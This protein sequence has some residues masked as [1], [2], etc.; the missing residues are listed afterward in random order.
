M[1]RRRRRG[2][3]GDGDTL[4]GTL[5]RSFQRQA[6]EG[7]EQ[8]TLARQLGK[9]GMLAVQRAQRT[10][11]M[12]QDALTRRAAVGIGAGAVLGGVVDNLIDNLFD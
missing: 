1:G 12:R 6:A 11:N 5:R 4:P 2:R 8:L 7:D 3:Q 9:V 10:E